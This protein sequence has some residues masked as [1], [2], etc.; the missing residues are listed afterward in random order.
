MHNLA[1][2]A[3]KKWYIKRRFMHNVMG[4]FGK[5]EF[6]SIQVNQK[7]KDLLERDEPEP[8]S[9]EQLVEGTRIS[10]KILDLMKF[11]RRDFKV[12]GF[13][14]AEEERAGQSVMPSIFVSPSV[15]LDFAPEVRYE[16][17]NALNTDSSFAQLLSE[18]MGSE[19]SI[20]VFHSDGT[21]ET[22]ALQRSHK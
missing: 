1:A 4:N 17:Y 13:K 8:K 14:I 6:S 11:P 7:N 21:T 5:V 16:H 18:Y 9:I 12:E 2:V 15:I 10:L 3:A 22:A 20:M 19:Q